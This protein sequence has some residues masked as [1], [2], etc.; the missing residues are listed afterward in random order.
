MRGELGGIAEG[1]RIWLPGGEAKPVEDVVGRRLSVLSYDKEW[2]TRPVRY[3]P[4]QGPRDHS[5]GQLGPTRP[6]GWIERGIESVFR[7]QF[8]SG[9]MV[10]VIRE[11]SWV[12]QRRT[13]RQ[14]WEWKKTEGLAI[15]DRVPI[16]LTADHQG[17]VRGREDGYF[18]GAM[19]GDGGMTSCTPEFHCD[20]ADGAAEFMRTFAARH[21]CGVREIPMGPIVRMRFPYRSGHR[22]PLTK[23]L[24]DYA[25]WG[26]RREG[27]ELPDLPLSREFLIG[28]LSGLIDTDGCVRERANRKGTLHGTVEYCTVSPRLAEQ[29]S[30]ALLRIGVASCTRVRSPA[31][32]GSERRIGGYAVIHRR[33]LFCVEV[34][35]ALAVNRLAS[36]L[37]L[38]IGY[39]AEKLRWLAD[40]LRHVRPA[41]SDM[42]GYDESVALD[43]VKSVAPVGEKRVYGIS[44]SPS[45]LIVVNGI[46]TC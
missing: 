21:G 44:V 38:R 12:T 22:N 32:G 27:K 6:A 10:E 23:V 20:P 1:C 26:Q 31:R 11:H 41:R 19:L 46:V 30:D 43:R 9:R 7:I 28:C 4:N 39:K 35:R 33:P 45:R 24:R 17:S 16:P 3:G 37:D 8:V 2:D 5:V 15:G 29:V 18:V 14:A 34:S 36:L 42:H 13:G 25:V 40:N